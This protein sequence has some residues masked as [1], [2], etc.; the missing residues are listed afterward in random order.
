[1]VTQGSSNLAVEAAILGTPTVELYV[2]SSKYPEYGPRGTWG[3]GLSDLILEAIARGPLKDFER[4]MN[5]D[6]DGRAV[7][8][9]VEWVRSICQ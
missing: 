2:C 7:E 6:A 3:E 9:T 5:Y 8:R 1:L 4:A